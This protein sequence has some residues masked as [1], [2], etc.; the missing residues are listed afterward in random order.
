MKPILGLGIGKIFKT[1]LLGLSL[2][3]L[4]LASGAQAAE[5]SAGG[6]VSVEVWQEGVFETVGELQREAEPRTA[7]GTVSTY[8]RIRLLRSTLSLE[9]RKGATFGCRERVKAGVARPDGPMHGV[10]MRVLHPPMRTPDG[11]VQTVSTA[12]IDWF[13]EGG[14]ARDDVMYTLSEDFE[15]LPGRWTLQL[16]LDGQV[17]ASREFTLR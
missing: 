16:L 14:V 17:L 10:E 11:R 15:V 5:G 12:A 3:G 9:A 2:C 7:A 1:L 4:A 13:F 6:L 8:E